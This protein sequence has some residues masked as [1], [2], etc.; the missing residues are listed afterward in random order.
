MRALALGLGLALVLALVLALAVR[1]V[2]GTRTLSSQFHVLVKT[3]HLPRRFFSCED[4]VQCVLRAGLLLLL[5]GSTASV[6]AIVHFGSVGRLWGLFE[7]S[8]AT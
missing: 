4:G 8:K 5:G 2:V 7:R 1:R 3:Y 6:L